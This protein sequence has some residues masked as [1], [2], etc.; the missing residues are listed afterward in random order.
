MNTSEYLLWFESIIVNFQKITK[1]QAW[2]YSPPAYIYDHVG[3]QGWA[4]EAGSAISSVFPPAHNC[5]HTWNRLAPG[6][7]PGVIHG[8]TLEQMLGVFQAATKQLREGRLSS[9]IDGIRTDA[10]GDLL[11]Q[12]A[13]L[14]QANHLAAA[15]VIAGGALES[16]LKHLVSKNNLAVT[17]DGSISKYNDAI[18]KARKD[19]IVEVYSATDTKHV[20][21]WGGIR[22]DAAHDPKSFSRTQAEIRLMID[23]IRHF[24]TRVK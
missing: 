5:C 13:E 11:D 20:T 1:H 7:Q 16:H 4:A 2:H 19:G 18:S 22:N 9:L 24:I 10:E 17:G 6:M 23:G 14:S 3:A 15:A 21:A 8:G 12:A